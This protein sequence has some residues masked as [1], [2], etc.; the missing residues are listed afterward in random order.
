MEGVP[1]TIADMIARVNDLNDGHMT[2]IGNGTFSEAE[3]VRHELG[4][5]LSR[6]H[7]SQAPGLELPGTKDEIDTLKD[8]MLAR[9]RQYGID[10]KRVDASLRSIDSKLT[11]DK[12][13]ESL[14]PRG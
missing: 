14:K 6:L 1:R 3:A 5:M 11:F 9:Y 12:V 7:N 8:L 13:F 4:Q 2:G 10:T